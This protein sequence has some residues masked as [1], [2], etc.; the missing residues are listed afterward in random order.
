MI[1]ER[2]LKNI[3][4]KLGT[5]GRNPR[6]ATS[7]KFP[8]EIVET[9][10]NK[11]NFNVG[12]TGVLTPWAELEPIM[13]DGVKISRATLHNRDEIERKDIR[14]NDLVELQRA[15]EV[16]PQIIMSKRINLLL[17]EAHGHHLWLV[18]WD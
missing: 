6:W 8:P 4:K 16:I 7:Y 18:I 5:S 9:K 12:R 3:Q 10:L 11:I 13:I 15:G 1:L 17:Q 14:E 2:Q